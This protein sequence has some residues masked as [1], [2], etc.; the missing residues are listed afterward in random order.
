M[1][2]PKSAIEI[3][4]RKL[5]RK[6]H[7]RK[8]TAAEQRKVPRSSSFQSRPRDRLIYIRAMIILAS[9][10][11]RRIE[12]FKNRGYDFKVIP[13]SIDERPPRISTMTSVP[14]FLSLKK[15]LDVESRISVS[16]P[17]LIIAADTVVYKERVIGKPSSRQEAEDILCSLAG[18]GH[19]VITGVTIMKAHTAVKRCFNAVSAVYFKPFTAADISA[20]LNTDEPYDKAG[21]Y[22]IQGYFSRYIDHYEGSLDN[23]IG[24]PMEE[25]EKI[26][27]AML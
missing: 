25:A 26:I 2:P 10:S 12:M 17:A 7:R 11:P 8:R 23:I 13:S 20:Y 27:A 9:A 19:H 3:I 18:T 5:L 21:G 4:N 6:L 16:G 15:A 24:F 22:A 1:F 14:M